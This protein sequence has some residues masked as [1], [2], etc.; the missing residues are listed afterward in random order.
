MWRWLLV[1]C[2][3]G[4]LTALAQLNESDTV[5]LQMRVAATGA[6]QAGNVEMLSLRG[7]VDMTLASASRR[8]AFKTQNAYLYQSFFRIKA[9]EDL[10]SR[11]F[12]YWQP[13]RRI[14][15][16]AMAF[17]ST[18]FRRQIDLRYFAGAGLTW[19]W[20]RGASHQVK[21]SLS[22]VYEETRFARQVF[23]DSYY[24]GQSA[25]RTWR[26]TTWLYGKHRLPIHQWL[27]HYEVYAQPGLDRPD[28]LRWQAEVG[29]DL[30]LYKGLY[31]T[32]NWL[33]TYEQVVALP[34]RNHDS[35]LTFG[36]QYS[37]RR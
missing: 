31:G 10:F 14:Y 27:L 16:F 2:C 18:N 30:P 22:A 23:N 20:R 8:W 26:L 29:L 28:N 13:D 35:L 4:P 15:P 24:D 34:N 9:D 36:L 37:L 5:R 12:V 3:C 33:Y 25:I 6:S 32:V 21:W 19:Q 17:V 1:W 7:K 11:N